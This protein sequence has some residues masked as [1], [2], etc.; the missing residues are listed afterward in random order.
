M[1]DAAV[2]GATGYSGVELVRLLSRHPQVR[3]RHLVSQNHAGEP[4]G[5]VFANYGHRPDLT[6]DDVTV[7]EAAAD[8]DVVFL[9]MPAGVAAAAV[10]P[11]VLSCTKVVDLGADFRLADPAVYA[12]W[13]GVAHAAPELL[14]EAVY[15]LTELNRHLVA[16]AGLIANPGC[17]TTCGILTLAPLLRE[18]LIQ[19]DGI[20]I[21]AKSGVTGAGRGAKPDTAFCECDENVSAYAV[22]THRHTPEFDEHLSAIAGSPVAVTFTPHLIPMNRGILATVYA[23]PAPGVTAERLHAAYE[24]LYQDEFFI[25]LMRPGVFPQTR[26]VKGSNFCDIGVTLDERTNTVIAVGALDN[27]GKGAAGQAVQNM[28]VM[29]GIDEHLG[30]E[31]AGVFPA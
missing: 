24:R 9:A 16:E 8:S 13:Y 30:L 20:V 17:Y 2:F 12:Q 31:D 1:I 22:T 5:A 3:L 15:G 14:R 21:D 25:R 28:N 18:G 23:K 26:W 27:L 4:Y 29:F 6:C 10:T 11:D 19:P 7:P